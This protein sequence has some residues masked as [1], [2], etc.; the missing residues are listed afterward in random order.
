VAGNGGLVRYS[1][2]ATIFEEGD[3]GDCMYIVRSGTVALS[4]GG[5]ALE[6]VG[7]GGLFG[8]M[9]LVD[10]GPRSACAVAASDCELTL[11]DA[12]RFE[13]MVQQ[14]PYFAVEVMR[15]VARR[16]REETAKG[17]TPPS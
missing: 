13:F 7:E 9:A 6:T 12:R 8:E 16:L 14:T 17:S 11:I 3:P 2:G 1:S 5:R 10:N 4:C 15:T